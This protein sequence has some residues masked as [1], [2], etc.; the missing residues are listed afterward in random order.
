[1][2]LAI[3]IIATNPA[4]IAQVWDRRSDLNNWRGHV[5]R[6]RSDE[7]ISDPAYV[8]EAAYGAFELAHSLVKYVAVPWAID[9]APNDVF[10]LCLM[11]SDDAVQA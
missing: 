9:L 3:P 5:A 1:M 6:I 4:A 7:R 8:H 10:A 2:T 11:I